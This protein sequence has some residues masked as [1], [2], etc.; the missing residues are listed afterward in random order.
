MH[1]HLFYNVGLFVIFLFFNERNFVTLQP[2]QK[3][4]TDKQFSVTS[5]GSFAKK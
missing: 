1:F 2:E 5:A 4:N 3:T